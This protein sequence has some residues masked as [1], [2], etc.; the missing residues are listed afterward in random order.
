MASKAGK[1][2]PLCRIALT[3]ITA[4]NFKGS[5]LHCLFRILVKVQGTLTQLVLIGILSEIQAFFQS[6]GYVIIDKKSM[7]RIN[8]LACLNVRLRQVFLYNKD[9]PYGRMNV[10]MCGDFY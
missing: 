10:L 6:I 3:S 4:Y 5:T 9:K 8:T 1:A 7:I 2:D